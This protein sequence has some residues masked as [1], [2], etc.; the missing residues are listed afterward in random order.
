[1]ANHAPASRSV[2]KRGDG[3]PA[4]IRSDH[5]APAET[6]AESQK[7]AHDESEAD[8]NEKRAA[9]LAA[10]KFGEVMQNAPFASYQCPTQIW[11]V[12]AAAEKQYVFT[13]WYFMA[14]DNVIVDLFEKQEQYDAADVEARRALA[15]KYGTRYAALGPRHSRFPVAIPKNEKAADKAI[16]LSLPSLVEQLAQKVA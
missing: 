12:K 15:R 14:K 5:A 10:D 9:L 7:R 1:M 2:E 13:R 4:S 16:R 6:R 3:L 11:G 8:F